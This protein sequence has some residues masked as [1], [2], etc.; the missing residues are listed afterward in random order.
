MPDVVEYVLYGR[1][2][3]KRFMKSIMFDTDLK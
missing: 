2:A 1:C 3:R